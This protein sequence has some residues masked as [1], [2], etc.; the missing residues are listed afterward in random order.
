MNSEVLSEVLRL[1]TPP[2]A[3]AA[4]AAGVREVVKLYRARRAEQTPLSVVL[5]PGVEVPQGRGRLDVALRPFRSALVLLARVRPARWRL[6]DR[7]PLL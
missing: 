4:L 6:V 7:L 2:A 3:A 1:L 5:P